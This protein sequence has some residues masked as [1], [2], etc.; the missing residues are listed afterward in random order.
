M[1]AKNNNNNN[2]NNNNTRLNGSY[3]FAPSVSLGCLGGRH[4][5]GPGQARLLTFKLG[6]VLVEVD[7]KV[8]QL[9]LGTCTHKK[10]NAVLSNAPVQCTT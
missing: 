8:Y 10:I 2:N 4:G 3:M 1:H 6:R 9:E 7:Y 5:L